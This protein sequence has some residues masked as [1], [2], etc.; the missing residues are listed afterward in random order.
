LGRNFEGEL[1]LALSLFATVGGSEVIRLVTDTGVV[2][3]IVLAILLVF[4]VFSWAVIFAKWS[5]FRQARAQSDR[6]LRAF[7]RSRK[8]SDLDA[9]S[10]QF[11]P[12]PLV[13]LFE[14]GYE[15]LRNQLAGGDPTGVPFPAGSLVAVQRALQIGASEQL[16]GMERMLSWLATTGAVT[17]FI[18]LFGTVWGI[19]DAFHGL[20]TAGA[21]SIRAVAP[22]ISEA[23]ITTAAGLFVAIPAVIFYNYFL[24]GLRDFGTRMDNFSLEFLNVAE[25]NYAGRGERTGS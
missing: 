19:M 4:S 10:Q 25:R 9:I 12:S 21:A 18:G 1:S 5:R 3:K 14:Y 15:E 24:H 13:A 22:G 16:T 17:P 11:R 20:G 7:R 6:F 2:A 8:L 23:L